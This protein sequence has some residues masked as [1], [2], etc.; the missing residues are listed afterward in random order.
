MK[1]AS[2]GHRLLHAW[3]AD[4][5][6]SSGARATDES[7]LRKTTNGDIRHPC[8][9]MK[10]TGQW[11]EVRSTPV[12]CVGK[13][14]CRW[15]LS[16]LWLLF[17]ADLNAADPVIRGMALVT[18]DLAVDAKGGRIGATVSAND[19]QFSA[20][21]VEIAPVNAQIPRN[22]P[23]G[24]EPPLRP[25]GNALEAKH[26]LMAGPDNGIQLMKLDALPYGHP[27]DMGVEMERSPV[28]AAMDQEVSHRFVIRNFADQPATNVTLIISWNPGTRRVVRLPPA[29]PPIRIEPQRA[30]ISYGTIEPGG[31]RE[32]ALGFART[33]GIISVNAVVQSDGLDQQPGNNDAKLDTM[34]GIISTVVDG[35]GF[36][37]FPLVADDAQF[38]WRTGLLYVLARSSTFPSSASELIALDPVSGE[39]KQRTQLGV[40]ADQIELSGDGRHLYIGLVG[41]NLIHRMDTASWRIDL[42]FAL[43]GPPIS[44]RVGPL[45]FAVASDNSDI[46]VVTRGEFDSFS[47]QATSV[48]VYERGVR[49]PLQLTGIRIPDRV[50]ASDRAGIFWGYSS[51]RREVF[52]LAVDAEGVRVEESRS[53]I[54][55]TGSNISAVGDLLFIGSGAVL[56]GQT[57]EIIGRLASGGASSIAIA[58]DPL[59]RKAYVRQET[60]LRSFD[61]D[62][63]AM[64]EEANLSGLPANFTT[65]PHPML[66]WGGGWTRHFNRRIYHLRTFT[67]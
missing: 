27:V 44:S 26:G 28:A 32:A 41:R 25:A 3:L 50:E 56:S 13:P 57:L 51:S 62:S 4:A 11:C 15:L 24:T 1:S 49:R 35:G 46:L 55:A 6:E 43:D 66:R 9:I 23:P 14:F 31:R 12:Q 58:P 5:S 48:A 20:S 10:T 60:L 47:S 52:R 63:L 34:A 8:F 54:D 17:M 36:R 2:S 53:G 59:S 45:D 37:N 61:L 39:L 33:A 18:G 65:L 29:D 16:L 42:Q 19:P 67:A 64:L 30:T 7:R 40:P 22:T 38:C 21:R